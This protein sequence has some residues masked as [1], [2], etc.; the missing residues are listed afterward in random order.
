MGFV[1]ANPLMLGGILLTVGAVSGVAAGLLGVG[2]GIIIVPVLYH[3]FTELGVDPAVRMHLAVGTSLTTIIATSTTSIRAH[4]RRGAVDTGLLKSWGP[5]IFVGVLGGT[6]LA[7][8]VRGT[9]LTA[10]FAVMATIVACY[11]AFGRPHWRLS[12][13]LPTGMLRHAIAAFIGAVSAMMG[14]GG[15]TLS[16]PTLTLFGY[17]IHKAVGTAAAIGLI[18]GI[19]GTIG[20]ILAGWDVPNRPAWSLGYVNVLGVAALLP[21]SMLLA[22]VGARLAHSLDTRRL[23]QVFAA[24]LGLTALRMFYGLL[25]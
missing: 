15:G 9:A 14:I 11:M 19:P 4:A 5:A 2:G 6:A 8:F 23:K 22:P 21:T 17:P 16:V 10:V 20:F 7:G 18:I 25:S 13:H 3:L 24:F 12:D 1:L